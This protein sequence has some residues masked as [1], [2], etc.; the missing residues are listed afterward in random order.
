MKKS[1]RHYPKIDPSQNE[2]PWRSYPKQWQFQSLIN[3]MTAIALSKAK[4]IAVLKFGR[5]G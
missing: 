2:R 5:L 3:K 1:D 4:G